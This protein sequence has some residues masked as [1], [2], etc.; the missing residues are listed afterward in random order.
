MTW[1]FGVC[2]NNLFCATW[3]VFCSVHVAD[4]ECLTTLA[5]SRFLK[6]W[7]ESV[8]TSCLPDFLN[9]LCKAG[10]EARLSYSCSA[11]SGDLAV[12]FPHVGRAWSLAGLV[13]LAVSSASAWSS[14]VELFDNIDSIEIRF[15][16]IRYSTLL[17]NYI[18]AFLHLPSLLLLAM[19]ETRLVLWTASNAVAFLSNFIDWSVLLCDGRNML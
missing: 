12:S 2:L 13:S 7:E 10:S 5:R 6:L 17:Y 18:F 16:V 15:P 11:V 19:R 9:P 1:V 3:G 4:Y 8:E 14:T